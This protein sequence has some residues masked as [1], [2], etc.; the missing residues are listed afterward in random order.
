M[1]SPEIPILYRDRHL[2]AVHKPA[3]MLVHRNPQIR[4]AGPPLLQRLRDQLRA[5]VFPVHR[6]DRPTSG[7][8]VFALDVNTARGLGAAFAAGQVHKSYLAVVRGHTDAAGDIDYPLGAKR[9]LLGVPGS[10]RSGSAQS[11]RTRYRSLAQV[12]LPYA[13]GRY[14][15]ARYGLL[16]V[17]PVTGRM[18]QI[19]RH[20]K[21]IN[22]HLIGDTTHGDGVHNRFFRE[23]FGCGRLL[24]A[25]TGLALRHPVTGV[26]VALHA[27]PNGA[28]RR[29]LVQLGW[30]AALAEY[31]RELACAPIAE[32]S[33]PSA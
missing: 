21:H 27:A 30:E 19:R 24:L 2:V 3:G 26:A 1:S 23:R 29:V 5:V 14:G 17:E 6:L 20:M 11:A 16:A 31:L 9:G 7:V 4:D 25:A 8:L 12:E 10:D 28:F 33:H 13:V 18:H 15:T 22:H 32:G